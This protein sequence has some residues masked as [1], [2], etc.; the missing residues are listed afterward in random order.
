MNRPKRRN[1]LTPDMM[2]AL[3]E[4]LKTL[5]DRGA[6][7]ILLRGEGGTFCSGLDLD[8]YAAGVPADAGDISLNLHIELFECPAIIVGAMERYAINGGAAFALACDVLVVGETSQLRIGEVKQGAP[9]PMNVAWLAARTTETVAMKLAGVGEPVVGPELLALGLAAEVVADDH[10]LV[11]AMEIAENLGGYP[12]D[13]PRSLKAGIRANS[14]VQ[15]ARA[16]F[17]NAKSAAINAGWVPRRV[18]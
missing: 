7:A 1:A 18:D 17:S 16:W 13:G 6:N 12:S 14:P 2:S 8:V 5:V 11:K 10:V 15:D 4:G 9:A 3:R